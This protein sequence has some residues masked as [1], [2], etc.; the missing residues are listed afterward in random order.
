MTMQKSYIFLVTGFEEIEAL[1][2]VDILRRGGVEICTV[3][4]TDSITVVGKHTVPVTADMMY[5]QVEFPHAEMIILPGGTVKIDE[6]DGLKKKIV[7]HINSGK[8]VAAICAA[9][10]VL[11]GLGLLHGVRATCYPG[12]E[13]YLKGAILQPEEAVVTDGLITTGRGPGLTCAF[14]LTLLG[15]LKGQAVA[16]E[17]ASQILLPPVK[18]PA[19]SL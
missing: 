10:M 17:V 6:H 18:L 5:A 13:S 9:P 15:L 3:S 12:M 14:A 2:T 8:R 7:A 11:G 1:A 19:V 16:D 4:L